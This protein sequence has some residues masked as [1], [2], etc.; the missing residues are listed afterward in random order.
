MSILFLLTGII[1]AFI[2]PIINYQQLG[3]K[4][5]IFAIIMILFALLVICYVIL[6]IFKLKTTKIEY[7]KSQTIVSWGNNQT[8]QKSKL[9]LH[10]FAVLFC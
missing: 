9:K 8:P 3:L 5:F 1:C 4:A 10:G 7:L 2:V 6:S